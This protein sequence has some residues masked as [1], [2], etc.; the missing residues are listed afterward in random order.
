LKLNI[1]N[2]NDLNY[3]IILSLYISHNML[4]YHT[5]LTYQIWWIKKV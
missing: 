5:R 2:V 3:N 4:K 1:Y